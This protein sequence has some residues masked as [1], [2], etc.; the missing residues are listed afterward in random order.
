MVGEEERTVEERDVSQ[1]GITLIKYVW[2][3][4]YREVKDDEEEHI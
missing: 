2:S 3:S 1:E 4:C